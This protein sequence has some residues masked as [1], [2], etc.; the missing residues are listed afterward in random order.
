MIV[1]ALES[2]SRIGQFTVR[3]D[4]AMIEMTTHCVRFRRTVTIAHYHQLHYLFPHAEATVCFR[5]LAESQTRGAAGVIGAFRVSVPPAN[6]QHTNNKNVTRAQTQWCVYTW[7]RVERSK[8][9]QS[10]GY[11]IVCV[12]TWALMCQCRCVCVSQ[13]H[14]MFNPVS[15]NVHTH[16]HLLTGDGRIVRAS[17]FA[18]CFA[19]VICE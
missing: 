6:K 18:E 13:N 10:D 15:A 1:L 8:S 3:V 7:A 17:M 12:C 14:R 5:M 19:Y 4:I 16:T 2:M 11:I 9:Q